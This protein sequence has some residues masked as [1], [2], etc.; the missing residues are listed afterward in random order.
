LGG[1]AILEIRATSVTPGA[2]I[3]ALFSG[4]NAFV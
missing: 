2:E 1:E 4:V 3:V